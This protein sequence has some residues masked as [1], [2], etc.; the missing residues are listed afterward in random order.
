MQ[1]Y[2]IMGRWL[3]DFISLPLGRRSQIF[4]LICLVVLVLFVYYGIWLI[5]EYL[6]LDKVYLI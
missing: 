2:L 3:F 4:K 5:T 1:H 6:N